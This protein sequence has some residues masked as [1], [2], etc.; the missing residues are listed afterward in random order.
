MSTFSNQP[1]ASAPAEGHAFAAAPK[2]DMLVRN[3]RT[4]NAKK[5]L[6]Q[7]NADL[8]MQLSEFTYTHIQSLFCNTV[9]RDPTVGELRLLDALDRHGKDT[10]ARI[11]VGELTTKSPFI[12]ETWADMMQKHGEL[13]GVG[14]TLRGNQAVAAPPCTLTDALSLTGH[15][16]ERTETRPPKSTVLLSAPWQEAVASAEGYT[17]VARL[18]V[19]D[20]IQTLW[21]RTGDPL[22]VTPSHTG[23]F[24]LYLPHAELG[25][26]R[27]LVA[28]ELDKVHP[29]SGDIRAI[30][31]KSLLLTLLEL[32]PGADLYADRLLANS[33][34]NGRIPVDILCAYPSV[35]ES[36]VCDYLLRVPLKQVQG[37]N[38]TLKAL[39]ITAVICG[40]VRS[41]GHTVIHIR[42]EAN[43]R[44]IPAADL[45]SASL[46][47]MASVYLHPMS[48]E[49]G[50][51]G[52]PS[53]IRPSMTRLPSAV[54]GQNGLT[55]NGREAVALTL[56]EGQ[57][58]RIPEAGVLVSTHSV[59]IPRRD[60]AFSASANAVVAV[61]DTLAEAGVTPLNMVV[62]VSLT[63]ASVDMLTDGTAISAICGI[64]RVAAERGLPVEDPVITVAPVE[65]LLALTVTAH[66]EDKEACDRLGITND[67]QWCT[68]GHPVHK[69][70]PCFLLPVL[71]RSYEGSLKALS[72][73]LNRDYGAG[74]VIRPM[75]MDTTEV[76]VAVEDF[77][78][79]EENSPATRKESRHTLN[80]DSVKSLC[81][82][83]SNWQIPVFSMSEDDTR[84]LLSE[85]TVLEALTRLTDLGYS[86]L[87]LG[88]SC[89]PFAEAGLLPAA[90]TKIKP[91]STAGTT[92]TVTYTF[93]ADAAT[94]LLRRNLLTPAGRLNEGDKHLLTLRL[95]DGTAIPDGFVGRQGKVLGLLN[96]VDTAVLPC[97][98]GYV[99]PI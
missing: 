70:S 5:L 10:P 9:R 79:G 39:G 40:Q 36:G 64:Y 93:P 1:P 31:Q 30:A 46:I 43:K 86:I 42:D 15:Y 96:G 69:E 27:T 81:E 32:C 19:G 13:H 53:P 25:K 8:E 80:P 63:A 59:S 50:D 88:D 26:I 54:C 58:L 73:A 76:E 23:D 4:S 62:S 65:G 29:L 55:P 83:F 11:A 49:Q 61:T 75:V 38:N 18:L 57:I 66:A 99:F 20:G 22:A 12:A 95:S 90:L 28:G 98:R 68:P 60:T 87:V 7:L 78:D 33:Q 89:K 34:G 51:G 82:Q 3:L 17:P 47:S 45:P 74:C 6:P 85:P 14:N 21:T 35:D 52:L 84:M 16:L 37:M 77:A 56:H 67:R 41:N 92:A 97:L 91:L 72:A 94:R 44:D 71:R 24:I 48:A 2:D